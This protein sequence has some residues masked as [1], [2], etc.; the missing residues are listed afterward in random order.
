MK[1]SSNYYESILQLRGEDRD[2]HEA[3]Q[4]VL[5]S[6]DVKGQEGVFIA[7]K[8][9]VKNGLDIYLSSNGF[10]VEVGRELFKKYGGDFVISKKLF[11]QH[12]QTSKILYRVTVLFRFP[13]FKLGEPILVGDDAF[14]VISIGKKVVLEGIET[15]RLHEISYRDALRNFQKPEKAKAIV[16]KTIP[17]LEVIHPKS[18]QSVPVFPINKKSGLSP[19]EKIKV[20]IHGQK[21][22]AA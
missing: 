10:A 21:V 9:R 8:K 1:R 12:K 17:H 20:L 6:I 15:C 4:H 5:G 16:S 22:W 14:K 2:I 18:Y 13:P 7:K 3:F 11:S 19:G